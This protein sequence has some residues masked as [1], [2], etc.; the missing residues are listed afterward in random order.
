M[1]DMGEHAIYV[2]PAYIIVLLVLGFNLL[3]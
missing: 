1:F 2:W 3:L